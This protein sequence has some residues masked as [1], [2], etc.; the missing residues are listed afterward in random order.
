MINQK[1]LQW[2][3]EH[4]SPEYIKTNYWVAV[5]ADGLIAM[6]PD[7]KV[8]LDESERWPIDSVVFAYASF[9]LWQ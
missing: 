6:S 8:V 4:W 2:L 7:F 1:A 9:E 5:S 3:R